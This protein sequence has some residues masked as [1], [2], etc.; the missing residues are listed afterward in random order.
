MSENYWE[1]VI[2]NTKLNIYLNDLKDAALDGFKDESDNYKQ[3]LVYN[4]L[5]T[6]RNNDQKKFFYILIKAINKPK[7][8][9]KELWEELKKCYDVMPEEAFVNF[10]YSMILGIMA[11]YGGEKNE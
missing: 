4:L 5:E 6:V 9:F 7:G 11:T 3:K 1:R 2:G 10:A 8:N